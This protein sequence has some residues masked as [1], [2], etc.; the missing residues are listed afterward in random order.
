MNV[1][2]KVL[3]ERYSKLMFQITLVIAIAQQI[4][5][6]QDQKYLHVALIFA[7][8]TFSEMIRFSKRNHL[9]EYRFMAAIWICSLVSVYE[10]IS[11]IP[12]SLIYLAALSYALLETGELI[13][14]LIRIVRHKEMIEQLSERDQKMIG[15]KTGFIHLLLYG[16]FTLL[17]FSGGYAII[18]MLLDIIN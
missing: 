15:D 8:M 6:P 9:R 14:S 2:M 18:Q 17:V 13:G 16:V 4:Y 12:L 11:A 7:Y 1:Q 3:W 10:S 5:Y